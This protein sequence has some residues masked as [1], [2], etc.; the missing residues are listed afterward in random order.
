MT[1]EMY[2]AIRDNATK[3]AIS[4]AQEGRGE[5]SWQ[6][7]QLSNRCLAAAVS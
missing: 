6:L 3:K 2:A 7:Q 5:A 4:K 1:V